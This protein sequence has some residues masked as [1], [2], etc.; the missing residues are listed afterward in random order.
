L[1]AAVYKL[2]IE[3]GSTFRLRLQLSDEGGPVDLTG[4]LARM[5]IRET[6][7][8]PQPLYE[9]TTPDQDAG[10]ITI[11]GPAGT[12]DLL[13]SDDDTAALTWL[14]GVY[15]LEIEAPDGDVTKLLKGEVTVEREVT[16]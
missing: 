2:L 5:Q 9:L 4:Y 6:L 1:A 16:R 3:Q 12:I 10:G 11:D 13:I 14:H 15:D 7:D 8:S